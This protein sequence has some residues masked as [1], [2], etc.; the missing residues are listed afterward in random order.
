MKKGFT[1]VELLAVITILGILA[2]VTFPIVLKQINNARSGIKDS[3]KQLIIDAAKDYMNANEEDF[4]GVDGVKYCVTISDLNDYLIDMKNE[5]FNDIDKSGG[6]EIL[7]KNGFKYNIVDE[8]EVVTI[9][10]NANGGNIENA[11]KSVVKGSIYG[12]LP[13]AEKNDSIFLGWYLEDNT[14]KIRKTS[15][16]SQDI[17][18]Y[19]HWVGYTLGTDGYKYIDR[20]YVGNNPVYYNPTTGQLCND[21]VEANSS[22]GATTGCLKWYAYSLK[23]NIVNMLLDHNINTEGTPFISSSDY[24]NGA[25]LAPQLGVTGIGNGSYGNYGNPDKGPLTLLNYLKTHT[26]GWNTGIRGDYLEVYEPYEYSEY[27]IDYHYRINYSNYKARLLTNAELSNLIIRPSNIFP[28]WMYLNLSQSSGF[29]G[30]WASYQ[31]A[32]VCQWLDE[33][34]YY[35]NGTYGV[36]PVINVTADIIF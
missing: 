32:K 21:Y 11:T 20:T 13:T 36:R 27:N 17:T 23:D 22:N 33:N 4:P 18:L 29:Y 1:L 3:Q 14:T 31:S 7:Y 26:S 12:N 35:S 19:A 5:S 6:V 10:F 25:T 24:S 8:C 2:L 15:V 34:G 30:Y 9:S 28:D 16:V